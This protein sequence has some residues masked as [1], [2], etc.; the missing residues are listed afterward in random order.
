MRYLLSKT[1]LNYSVGGKYCVY[2]S[3]IDLKK[4][5]RYIS[6]KAKSSSLNVQ[7]EDECNVGKVHRAKVE[8]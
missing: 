3:L 2:S 6:L 4:N 5:I 8:C 1:A 7:V